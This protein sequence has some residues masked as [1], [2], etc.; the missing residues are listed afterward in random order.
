MEQG[1]QALVMVPEISLTT[2]WLS[3]FERRF[4]V[5]P[6]KWHSNLGNKER[7]DTWKAIVE[8]RAKVIIGARSALYL[9]YADLGVIIVDESHD[10]SYKQEDAVNYQGRDM[11]VVRGKFEQIPVILSTARRHWKR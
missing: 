5:V 9:P 7:A 3:R 8:N 11:A 1:K 4:G 6:A 2:Q 10:S